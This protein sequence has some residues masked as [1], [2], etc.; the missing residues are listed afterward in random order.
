MPKERFKLIP[1]VY[2][3]L[4]KDG[5]ILLSRRFQTGFE[6]G[7]Y[8]LPSGHAEEKETMREAMVREIQEEIG[9]QVAIEDLEFA[10]MMHRSCGDHERIDFFFVVKKWNEEPKNME[11][12]KCDDLSWFLLDNLPDST[13]PY[14][15]QAIESFV[16]KIPYSEFGWE[17]R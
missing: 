3:L 10:H 6:D 17:E 14:I 11:P 12:E 2:L 5:K 7:K 9:A 8:G 15:R 16:N 13:I 4:V 1:S